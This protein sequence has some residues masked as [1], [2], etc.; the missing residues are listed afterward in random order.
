MFELSQFT[1]ARIAELL[2]CRP[3]G[4]VADRRIR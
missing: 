2:G 1:E 4:R 3:S